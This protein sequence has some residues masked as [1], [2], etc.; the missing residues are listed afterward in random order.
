VQGLEQYVV[1]GHS[2]PYLFDGH[3][4]VDFLIAYCRCYV[5][6]QYALVRVLMLPQPSHLSPII[7]ALGDETLSLVNSM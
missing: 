5:E 4:L 7:S 1:H 2:F 6:F 3:P